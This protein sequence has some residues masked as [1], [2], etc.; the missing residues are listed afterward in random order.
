MA[1]EKK[2][3][4]LKRWMQT[5][6]GWLDGKLFSLDSERAGSVIVPL[7][8][9]LIA[10]FV[11]GL[12]I[13]IADLITARGAAKTFDTVVL[14]A[15]V[16]AVLALIAFFLRRDLPAFGSAGK[17]IGRAAYVVLLCGVASVLG[18]FLSELAMI[19]VI[20]A[21]VLWVVYALAFKNATVLPR[22]IRLDNGDT[23][24]AER[25][26]CGEEYYSDGAG[27]EYEKVSGGFRR[28]Y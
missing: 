5:L 13:A 6:C 24:Y 25:G 12:T 8:W 23:L 10:S 26:V 3:F 18:F 22:K 16:V 27:N 1:K 15:G 7:W 2:T 4:F 21:F 28:K 9:S 17:K 14:V 20:C 11:T 19:I